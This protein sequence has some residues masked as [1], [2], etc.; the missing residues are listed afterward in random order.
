MPTI[1][2]PAKVIAHNTAYNQVQRGQKRTASYLNY[3]TGFLSNYTKSNAF[4]IMAQRL[5]E[6]YFY[7]S[8]N[9]VMFQEVITVFVMYLIMAPLLQRIPGSMKI[10]WHSGHILS[11]FRINCS[12]LRNRLRY[13]IRDIPRIYAPDI[14][15]ANLR[16]LGVHDALMMRKLHMLYDRHCGGSGL[17]HDLANLILDPIMLLH[18]IKP[19]EMRV[20]NYLLRLERDKFPGSCDIR[21]VPAVIMGYQVQCFDTK[22]ARSCEITVSEKSIRKFKYHI[23]N[24]LQ[25]STSPGK[26]E[27]ILLSAITDFA[28][29]HKRAKSALPQ[30]A[31]LARWFEKELSVLHKTRIDTRPLPKILV[32]SYLQKVDNRLYIKSGN[33]FLAPELNLNTYLNVF[34]PYR[35][36]Q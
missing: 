10:D 2:S 20:G 15:T 8:I 9:S 12:R 18:E 7:Q 21:D 1:K 11:L 6:K 36:V 3:R 5:A 4:K 26:K 25:S 31:E 16:S 35:E 17:Q 30:I 14:L 27:Q 24:V 32:N 22:G 29:Q 33:L 28:E 23:S 19:N 34:T 13:A